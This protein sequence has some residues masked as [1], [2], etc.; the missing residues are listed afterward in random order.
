MNNKMEEVARMFGKELEEGFEIEGRTGI[1]KLTEK[2]LLNEHRNIWR[3]DGPLTKLLTGKLK[4]KWK[5]ENREMCY[6][7]FSHHE[8][9]VLTRYY[10][11][12]DQDN[13]ILKRGM[14]TRTEEEAI[15]IMKDWGWWEEWI[16]MN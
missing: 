16:I 1:Y 5:P 6:F 13:L 11:S 2:G 14:I 12:S 10:S 7:V 8:K 3:I 9:P 15:Q 4:I